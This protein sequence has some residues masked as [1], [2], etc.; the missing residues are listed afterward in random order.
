VYEEK[1]A[2]EAVVPV[3]YHPAFFDN[4]DK[5]EFIF[6]KKNLLSII[7][8]GYK[9]ETSPDSMKANMTSCF[10]KRVSREHDDFCRF[11]F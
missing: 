10:E 7:P 5:I 2:A 6:I 3:V 4:V 9:K 11:I 1:T 8:D